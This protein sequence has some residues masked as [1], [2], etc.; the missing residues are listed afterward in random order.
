MPVESY[1][2]SQKRNGALFVPFALLAN[3]TFRTALFIY[4]LSVLEV[5]SLTGAACHREALGK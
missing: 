5:R 2:N 4:S 1:L 3:H